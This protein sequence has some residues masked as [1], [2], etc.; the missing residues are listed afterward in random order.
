MVQV[1]DCLDRL[2][3]SHT[4]LS[5]I[6]RLKWAIACEVFYEEFGIFPH[7]NNI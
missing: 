5:F 1:P 6:L 4:D 2:N 7:E 3:T